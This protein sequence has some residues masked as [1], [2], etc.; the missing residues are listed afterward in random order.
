MFC[1][2][3]GAE[4][5]EKQLFCVQC[6]KRIAEI[7][8]VAPRDN[9]QMVTAT[10]D[11]D[12]HEYLAHA[13]RLEVNRYT[14]QN[15]KERLQEKINCLGHHRQFEKP[16]I[17]TSKSFENFGIYFGKFFILGFIIALF[18]CN[19]GNGDGVIGRVI[20]N[21]LSILLFFLYFFD[22]AENEMFTGFGIAIAAA[23]AF[24]LVICIY[25]MLAMQAAYNAE[26][27][28]YKNR[29]QNDNV[30]VEKEKEKIVAL[31]AQQAELDAGI[32]KIDA[33]R[34]KLYAKNVIHPKYRELIPIVTMFE[35]FDTRR[36][37]TLD[38]PHGAY[39][40]YEY[41]LH[42]KIII[43]NLQQVVSMLSRI[44]KNQ[45][46]LYS[47]IQESNYYAERMSNQADEM[48]SSSRAIERNTEIAAYNAKIAA[49][50]TTISAYIDF[51]R[52]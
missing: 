48:L 9:N 42:Q 50:N 18:V 21:F 41:E 45:H 30:R 4:I 2:N 49:E 6:G 24:S 33:M 52:F 19:I 8:A 51:C 29:I 7:S 14:L 31:R 10:S 46:A 15:A 34:R 23:L 16:Y 1:A 28:K 37:Y 32:R 40:T 44:E 20:A 25:R 17:D 39:D 47:A 35:Y 11:T 12:I 43:A 3:C 13:K 38:G 27:R 26:M 5:T 36:C 22:G